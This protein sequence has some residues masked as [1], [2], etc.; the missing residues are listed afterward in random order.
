MHYFSIHQNPLI[1]SA[2]KLGHCLERIN[3]RHRKTSAF[4]VFSK[5]AESL[6]SATSATTAAK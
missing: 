2:I 3:A 4:I 6:L 5:C 1:E